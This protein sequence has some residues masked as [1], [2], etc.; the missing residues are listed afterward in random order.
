MAACCLVFEQKHLH[1]LQIFLG[2]RLFKGSGKGSKQIEY[3]G[4]NGEALTTAEGLA[5]RKMVEKQARDKQLVRIPFNQ[6]TV[7]LMKRHN[8]TILSLAE[9]TGISPET[10]KNMRNDPDRVFDIRELVAFCIA[11]HLP[12]DISE[13]YINTSL[14]K[15]RN[16]TDMELYR[17]ALTQWYM[18]PLPIVNRKLVE[19]G[20]VPLTNLVDGFDEKGVRIDA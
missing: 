20:A 14:S 13:E 6:M 7:D 12:P 10:I 17:Y 4:K 16:T 19:A 18:Q 15:Y 3:C 1:Q 8:V 2:G 11:L 5:L 9:A